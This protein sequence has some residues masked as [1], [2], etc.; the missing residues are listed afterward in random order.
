MRRHCHWLQL[1]CAGQLA[2]ALVDHGA[3]DAARRVCVEVADAVA[4]AERNWGARAG[5]AVALLRLAE[6]RLIAATD[7]AGLPTLHRAVAL[8]EG[9]GRPTL[10]VRA[11][12]SLAEAHWARGDRPGARTSLAR[13]REIADELPHHL[14]AR[15]LDE[16]EARI[17][18]S[19]G[20]AARTAGVLAED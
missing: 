17:G 20:E 10:V 18:H 16:L 11:L 13:A 15:K 6:G 1:Q 3:L 9:S 4:A 12:T 2:L 5:A 14:A 8:A 19:A 7:A